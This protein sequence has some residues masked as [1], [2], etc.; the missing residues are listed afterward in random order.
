MELRITEVEEEDQIT[1][2]TLVGRLDT[3]GVDEVELEFGGAVM[4]SRR[5]AIVDFSGVT[6]LGSLGIR[7]LIGAARALAYHETKMVVL[8]PQP[9]VLEAMESASLD[10]II[11][12]AGSAEEAREMIQ[13]S[14]V[15]S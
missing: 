14:W 7:M 10:E 12:V 15:S 9:H 11:P 6:F 1:H 2:V 5:N 8:T 4:A 13:R 3:E